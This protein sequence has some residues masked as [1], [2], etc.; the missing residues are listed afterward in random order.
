MLTIIIFSILVSSPSDHVFA[1]NE[2]KEEPEFF[3]GIQILESDQKAILGS[4]EK[5]KE[6]Q[7]G[8]M[9]I[10]HPMEQSWNLTLVEE[11]IRKADSL[12]LYTIFE[13]FNFSDHAI[14]ISPE[15][16]SE[17]QS[18]YPHLYA[19]L[20]Q[21]VTGKQVDLQLW[22]NNSTGLIKT[23]L[24]AEQAIIQ[25]ITTSMK[26]E[27]FRNYGAKILL[28][29]NVVSYVSANTSYCDVLIAKVFNAP[30]TELMI[31]LTRGMAK[32]YSIPEWGLWV[33]TWREWEKPPAFT[34]NDVERVLYEG[35]FYGAKYFFFEQGNFFGSFDR[36]WDN[37]YIILGEDGKLTDYGK[38]LQSFFIFLQNQ[39]S[40]KDNQPNYDS[41]IAVMIGQ[42]GWASRGKDWGLWEQSDRQGDFDYSLLNLFF[43]GIG[44]NW[45][46][47]QTLTSKE[48]TGLP[49]G[50]VDIISIYTPAE[51]MKQY[52]LIIGLGWTQMSNIIASNIENYVNNG[53]VFFSFLS[54]THNNPLVDDLED[55]YAWINDFA[56]LFGIKV[57]SPPESRLNIQTDVNLFKITFTEDTFWHPWNG[58]T[59]RYVNV[60]E[61][62]SWFWKYKYIQTYNENTTVLAWVN[63]IQTEHNAFIIEH[64]KGLGYTYLVNTRN[65]NS[66]PNGPLTNALTNFIYYLS[67]HYVKPMTF[68]VY[69][70][71]E[72]WLCQGQTE[73]AVYL[74]HDNSTDTQQFT[75]FVDSLESNYNIPKKYVLFEGLNNEY[76]GVSERSTIN[77]NVTLNKNEAKLF[78]FFK[79]NDEPQV[80]YSDALLAQVPLFENLRLKV[81]LN[82]VLEAPNTTQIYCSKFETPKYILGAPYNILED[83]NKENN[84]LTI[85]SHSDIIISW[86][87]STEVSIVESTA[88]LTEVLW[89]STL[90]TLTA[91]AKGTVG[92]KVTMKL[93]TNGKTPYYIRINGT[94]TNEWSYDANTDLLSIN[95][96]LS[97]DTTELV[98]G[99]KP[100]I[101]DNIFVSDERADLGSAQT[102][103]FHVSHMSNSSDVE[104]ASVNVNGTKH[105][106]NATGW[107]SFDVSS[108]VV[109]KTVWNVTDIKFEGLSL[110]S[111]TT[112]DPI[113]IWDR[114]NITDVAIVNELVPTGTVQTLWLTAE[115]EYDSESFD[116][117]KGTMYLNGKK[118]SWSSQNKR[119]EQTVTSNVLGPIAYEVTNVDD[120]TVGLKSI[121]KNGMNTTLRWDGIA[122]A[123]IDFDS[124]AIGEMGSKIYVEFSYSKTP[125]GNATVFVNGKICT[126][127][128]K[129][130]YT[131]TLGG[132][133][134]FERFTI[135][136]DF[137]NF[138]KVTASVT[139]IQLL[140]TLV[141]TLIG[142]AILLTILFLYI[143]IKRRKQKL[144]D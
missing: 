63:N 17:W 38:V 33:D 106:T 141:Y 109:G 83:Y 108:D 43:P 139:S 95:F 29:E 67:A 92:Q 134:P 142:T 23:R 4:I 65:S 15:L 112:A 58:Q 56:S 64:K 87:N 59:Y 19:I 133:N 47:G 27:E 120:K 84:I 14:R 69:P 46:I 44:D 13:A 62:D 135:E 42:S 116:E 53:G 18:K 28:Q 111:K 54:F 125:I 97:S 85:N 30:N 99:F 31:G 40:L 88:T 39:N 104:G 117:T 61:T 6:L 48:F 70:K 128:E 140:N 86:E 66:L 132:F 9:I 55:P 7:L 113:I 123:K 25:N 144:T 143:K 130:I 81:F 72:Y 102:V 79:D 105:V 51:V 37:K 71:N 35:W 8:N 122:L 34:P 124:I 12:G 68:L 5:V 90:G 26:L 96:F 41:S 115:Y 80:L 131:C 49:F 57:M 1:Q 94:E 118:M 16:F 114:I 78:F 101:I 98:F 74:I 77:L 11:A 136:A 89:N 75:Y 52:K 20:V 32:S 126:E 137:A 50:M 100:I 73:Q 119:W 45:Q 10:L 24:Q 76:Y 82:T 121:N 110:Y 91:S 22:E 2:T 129:G 138:E 36:D 60:N 103:G 3:M 127:T 21:E 93:Q 107:A